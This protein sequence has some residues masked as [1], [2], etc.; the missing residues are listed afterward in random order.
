MSL[1]YLVL[2]DEPLIAMDL[3]FAIE[4]LAMRG[5]RIPHHC[6]IYYGVGGNAK[7]AR[8]RL[9]HRAFGD[10]HKWVSPSVFDKGVRD[11]FRKQGHEFYGALLCTIREAPGL[12]PCWVRAS[13]QSYK[14]RRGAK[15]KTG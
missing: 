7:G 4:S 3:E 13:K 8:S 5:I 12:L 15:E 14:C 10:G 11:E 6:V 9:R 1:T 2:E